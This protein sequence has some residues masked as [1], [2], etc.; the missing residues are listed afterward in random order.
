MLNFKKSLALILSLALVISL[1][2]GL[3]AI[4]V[5]AA[6]GDTEKIYTGST[7]L[8]END[9]QTANTGYADPTIKYFTNYYSDVA[10]SADPDDAENLV[11]KI[12]DTAQKT[13]D[14]SYVYIGAQYGNQATGLS[15]KQTAEAQALKVEAGNT[16]LIEFKY[17]LVGAPSHNSYAFGICTVAGPTT[18]TGLNTWG[19][20]TTYA[21]KQVILD[22]STA[23]ATD[24]W[25]EHRMFYSLPADADLSGGAYLAIYSVMY[26]KT[27][28][29]Y[30]DDVKVSTMPKVQTVTVLDEDDYSSVN[31]GAANG[32]S[33]AYTNYNSDALPYT[34]PDNSSN[35]AIRVSKHAADYSYVY[36]GSD[37]GY[38]KEEYEYNNRK[39]NEAQAVTAEVGKTYMVEFDYKVI[40]AATNNFKMGI[41]TVAGPTTSTGLNQWDGLTT[42]ANSQ[43]ILNKSTVSA[44]DGW[45]SYKG[46]YTLSADADLSGGAY[47]AIYNVLY[48]GLTVY[49]DNLKISVI[50]ATEELPLEDNV[51][52]STEYA[53]AQAIDFS[54]NWPIH[55]YLVD[56]CRDS[57][58]IMDV[59]T[60][61]TDGTAKSIVY[62]Q[63]NFGLGI[64]PLGF[65]YVNPGNAETAKANVSAQVINAKPNTNYEIQFD[66]YVSGTANSDLTIGVAQGDILALSE[67]FNT[68]FASKVTKHQPHIVLPAGTYEGEWI[69][70]TATFTSTDDD[71]AK[72]HLMLY[73]MSGAGATVYIDNVT[74][75]EKAGI[76]LETTVDGVSETVYKP[77]GKF[78]HTDFTVDGK[79]VMWYTDADCTMP[80]AVSEYDNW[81]IFE[82]LELYGVTDTST[83][84]L[85]KGDLSGDNSVDAND[86]AEFKKALLGAVEASSYRSD[87]NADGGFDIVDLVRIK[88][89]VAGSFKDNFTVLGTPLIENSANYQIVYDADL[90]YAK[91]QRR[92]TAL[93]ELTGIEAV[94][95]SNEDYDIEGKISVLYNT[96]FDSDSYIVKAFNE[97]MIYVMAGSEDALAAAIDTFMGLINAGLTLD[98]NTFI[99]YAYTGGEYANFSGLKKV[100]SYE[101]DELDNIASGRYGYE[102]STYSGLLPYITNIGTNYGYTRDNIAVEDGELK[103]SAYLADSITFGENTFE[104]LPVGGMVWLGNSNTVNKG[105]FEINAKIPELQAGVCPAVWMSSQ[106]SGDSDEVYE[107]DIFEYF[108]QQYVDGTNTFKVTPIMHG[109]EDANV[110]ENVEYLA[111]GVEGLIPSFF[112]GFVADGQFHKYALEWTDKYVTWIVDDIPVM[113]LTL[114]ETVAF[115]KD[116]KFYIGVQARN[117]ADLTGQLT[118]T[119]RT[120]YLIID[121]LKIYSY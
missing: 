52:F 101:F 109:Y 72:K 47:I 100:M 9:Y 63:S 50:T 75:T 104:N 115:D 112:N 55:G 92:I 42:Y 1:F 67:A 25:V 34:D 74:V 78:S 57:K 66:Y 13:A 18:S 33:K 40:G 105:Y 16:Y 51:L 107:L 81:G 58:A 65:E 48:H 6:A 21:N 91:V 41:C 113:R 116:M 73:I 96:D 99:D 106:T 46:T 71:N 19:C 60:G 68:N 80:F 36:F 102:E 61:S 29:A 17:K 110:W 14:N 27:I 62:R 43:E 87:I 8:V 89:T 54:D 28:Q 24:G 90:D 86:I 118:S 5:T 38:A 83:S 70:A 114:D 20:L 84:A 7:V 49:Y 11:V 77:D 85:V 10:P 35:N 76:A 53:L 111:Q 103:L 30:I 108:G 64:V 88:K 94:V 23:S 39:T 2:T 44:T 121:S 59:Y 26:Q 32:G 82:Q 3:T 120:D 56:F 98:E 79:T 37:Y 45:A 93:S 31:L 15:I 12:G 95:I 4:P 117:V 69:T 22:K 119:E 97:D